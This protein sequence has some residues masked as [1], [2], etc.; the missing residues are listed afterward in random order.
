LA[1]VFLTCF[2]DESSKSNQRSQKFTQPP[3]EESDAIKALIDKAES[4]LQSGKSNADV[5]S[6]PD[7]LGAH[8]W[9]RFRK[10]IRQHAR[11]STVR[12]VCPDEPGIPLVVTGT[13]LD[14]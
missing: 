14:Q 10:L 1:T 5:L 9:P 12:M 8:D 2:G 6:D 3:E 13:V 7:Y 11:Q 4:A